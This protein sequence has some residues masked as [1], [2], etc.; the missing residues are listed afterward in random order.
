[1]IRVSG[2]DF[3]GRRLRG[4]AD[5]TRPATARMRE[6]IFNRGDVQAVVEG[7]VLDL[8]AGAGLLGVEALSRGAAS[9]DFVE[10]KRRACAVVR[11]NIAVVEGEARSRVLCRSVERALGALAPPY[12]LCFADPPYEVDARLVL[13][14]LA[15][16]GVVGPGGLLLWRHARRRA[17]GEMLGPLARCD[18]R[19]YGDGVLETYQ[20]GGPA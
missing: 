11:E 7:R 19:R 8:Y 6:S 10:R 3:A 14:R 13:E 20:A 15:E 9:V 18:Q 17:A 4:A 2:G 5:G 16:A 1:M 12:D